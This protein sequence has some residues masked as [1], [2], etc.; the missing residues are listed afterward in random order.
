M[1]AFC[2]NK[3]NFLLSVIS[4]NRFLGDFNAVSEPP[5]TQHLQRKEHVFQTLT[6]EYTWD[7][8]KNCIIDSCA[9]ISICMRKSYNNMYTNKT[10]IQKNKV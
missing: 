8:N 7:L 6:I 4:F 10:A 5:V 1:Q 9:K 2:N 3:F